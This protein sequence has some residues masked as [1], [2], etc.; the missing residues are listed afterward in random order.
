MRRVAEIFNS[1]VETGNRIL[2]KW[3]DEPPKRNYLIGN[4][5]GSAMKEWISP[6]F[7]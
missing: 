7:S 5:Q 3:F 6:A 1:P 4:L 2:L